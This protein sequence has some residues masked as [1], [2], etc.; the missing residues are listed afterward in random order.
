MK[1]DSEQ[2]EKRDMKQKQYIWN[3]THKV[4]VV[5]FLVC[6]KWFSQNGSSQYKT[7]EWF[8]YHLETWVNLKEFTDKDYIEIN[9]LSWTTCE[10]L[11]QWN[12]KSLQYTG[13]NRS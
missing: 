6:E 10:A 1:F 12:E 5:R 3:Q 8:L 4:I 7:I 9:A 13:T 2:G 11:D